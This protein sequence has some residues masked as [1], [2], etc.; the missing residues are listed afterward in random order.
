MGMEKNLYS[1]N[2]IFFSHLYI[3]SVSSKGISLMYNILWM[4][5]LNLSLFIRDKALKLNLT[6]KNKN[7]A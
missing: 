3:L 2:R 6:H 5:Y 4:G 7:S 1:Y